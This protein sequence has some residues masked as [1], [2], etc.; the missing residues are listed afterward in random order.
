MLKGMLKWGGG[1]SFGSFLGFTLV[2]L[3]VVIA[4]IGVLIALLL[5]AIQAAREAARRTQC[6]NH[7]KQIGIGIHNFHD[8]MRG[9]PPCLAGNNGA[10]MFALIYPF[11][12]QSA[13][14]EQMKSHG[15]RSRFGKAWW[16]DLSSPQ[17]PND[18]TVGGHRLNEEQRRAFG[19][20][21]YMKCPSRRAGVQIT[22]TDVGGT[23]TGAWSD[24]FPG[25][26]S[27]YAMM[28]YSEGVVWYGIHAE[29]YV[30]MNWCPFRLALFQQGNWTPRD[31]FA[32]ISDGLSNQILVG[33]KHI[34]QHKFDRCPEIDGS[35]VSLTS[36]RGDDCSYLTAGD[37]SSQASGRAVC[38]IG[39]GA[40][41]ATEI[42][43]CTT[44]QQG[45]CVADTNGGITQYGFGGGHPGICNFLMGDASVFG[46]AATTPVGT[47]L[48]YFAQVNDGQVVSIP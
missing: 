46:F 41:V 7:L 1:R 20:V 22:E 48:R 12:E 26:K 23:D 43:L 36:D 42:P 15:L 14:Y 45:K 24:A 9:I 8:T 10:S 47:I 44:D 25:P 39:S 31:T 21:P 19:S 34:P 6:V 13:L 16:N 17:P 37:V 28:F 29:T 35:V 33:E 18:T 30:P 32:W 11:M 3:L 2:E 5:P 38:Y 27:D 40:T 4:I